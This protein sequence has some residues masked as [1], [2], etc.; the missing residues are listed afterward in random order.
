M[1]HG[2]PDDLANGDPNQY[3]VDVYDAGSLPGL[4]LYTNISASFP[5]TFEGE[6]NGFL[7]SAN[8]MLPWG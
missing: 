1:G 8:E 7:V 5:V 3:A 2:R 4:R 6:E